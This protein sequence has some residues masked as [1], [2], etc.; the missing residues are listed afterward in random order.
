MPNDA[1]HWVSLPFFSPLLLY[2]VVYAF[3]SLLIAIFE[4][5]QKSFSMVE[6]C[7]TACSTLGE[8]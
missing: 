4:L 8:V 6:M 5:L 3:E 2:R 7:L 1:R